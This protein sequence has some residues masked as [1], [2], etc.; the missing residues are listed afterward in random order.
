[1]LLD[2]IKETFAD[3]KNIIK[4]VEGHFFLVL[5]KFEDEYDLA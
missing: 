4:Q 5:S 1:M 2:N 3:G